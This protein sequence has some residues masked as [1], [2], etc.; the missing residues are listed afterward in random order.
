MIFFRRDIKE[1]PAINLETRI[2]MA[3]FPT[4]QGGPHNNAIAAIAVQMKEITSLEFKAYSKQIL[5][6]A[7]ILATALIS[8]GYKLATDGTDNHLI[9]WDLR[10]LKL[11]G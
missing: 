11:S 8:K 2:N 4:C 5:K 7:T 3:V 6:N 10:P 9:L 1:G